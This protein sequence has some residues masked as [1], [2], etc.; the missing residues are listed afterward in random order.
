MLY[1]YMATVEEDPDGGFLVTFADVPEAITAGDTLEESMDN[2]R[3][4][5][6]LALRGILQDDRDL[7]RPEARDGVPVAVA[8]DEAA[9]L[10]VVQAFRKAGISKAELAR[11]LG[12][13]ETEARRIL[14]PDHGTK[15]GLLQEALR[16]LGQEIV[17]S[18]REAA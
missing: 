13:T 11:R 8:A 2:A 12:K 4:A 5:L 15:I 18:V 6:G 1:Q 16:A 10:A 9:K 17:I 3:E 7:P 14:D